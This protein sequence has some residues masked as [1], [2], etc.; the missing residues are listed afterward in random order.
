MTTS[1]IMRYVFAVIAL[2]VTVFV[3][4]PPLI[5]SDE[6]E[7]FAVGVALLLASFAC[8]VKFVLVKL[9]KKDASND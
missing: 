6:W 8:V 2:L 5:S 7:L 9:T 3:L 1:L 4:C